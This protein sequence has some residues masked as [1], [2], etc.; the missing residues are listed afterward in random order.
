MTNLGQCPDVE[1]AHRALAQ[2]AQVVTATTS[3]GLGEAQTGKCDSW[4]NT[5]LNFRERKG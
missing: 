2:G 5:A 3:P 1:G 4:N